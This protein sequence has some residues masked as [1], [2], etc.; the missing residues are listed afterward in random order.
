[1][2][3]ETLHTIEAALRSGGNL[4]AF[5]SGG[6][7]RV[8]RIETKR[9]LIA[10]GEYIHIDGALDMAAR[11]YLAGQ[12]VYN[13]EK[14]DPHFLTGSSDV[15]SP[16]DAWVLRGRTIDAA[17]KPK[18][19]QDLMR[20]SAFEVV[21]EGY[22]ELETP[23]KHHDAVR[24]GAAELICWTDDR[25]VV[26]NTRAVR[27]PNGE[28]GSS[29]SIGSVPKGMDHHDVWMWES[30]RLGRGATLHEALEAALVAKDEPIARKRD[31]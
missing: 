15:S 28:I 30:F 20:E 7:L 4:H 31:R 26:L 27:F 18:T 5:R 16:L 21:L 14:P 17:W 13:P 6:G 2:T 22:S 8:V 23:K 19:R 25:G 10:Y 24:T 12:K 3:T 9:K 29:T 1:M 11:D